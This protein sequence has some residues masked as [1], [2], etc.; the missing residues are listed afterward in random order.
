MARGLKGNGGFTLIEIIGVLAVISILAS[1][2]APKVFEVIADSRATRVASDARTF[3]TA[4]ADWFSDVGTLQGLTVAGVPQLTTANF[5]T[6]LMTDASAGAGTGRWARWNG[7]YLDAL[8]PVSI[9]TISS[10]QNPASATAAIATPS[11][12]LFDLNDDGNDD[13]FTRQVV[14]IAYAN[15]ATDEFAR[16]DSIIDNGLTTTGGANLLRGRATYDAA[17]STMYVYLA[18]Q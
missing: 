7:P 13:T 12:I 6:Q 9:A 17:T 15:V 1:M 8:P 11:N 5:G 10:Q 2:V 14:A 16:V 4:A 18:A 3:A